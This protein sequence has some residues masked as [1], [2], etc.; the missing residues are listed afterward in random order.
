MYASSRVSVWVAAAAGRVRWGGRTRLVASED[1][2]V[3]RP[4]NWV[5]GGSSGVVSLG[6]VRS[7]WMA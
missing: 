4:M 7:L 3:T 2:R 5:G 6:G 1:F